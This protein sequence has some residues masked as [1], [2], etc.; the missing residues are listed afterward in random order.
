MAKA[1]RGHETER[2]VGDLLSV[3]A[4]VEEPRLAQVYTHLLRS[5]PT[6]VEGLV[7]ELDV[8]QSTAYSDAGTLVELGVVTR[9]ESERPNRFSAEGLALTLR[10]GGAEYTVTA[11]LIA[12]L[13]RRSADPDLELFVER[14]GIERLAA[15]LEYAIPYTDGEMSERVA[16]RELGLQAVEGITILQTLREVV[17]AM[18]EHDPFFERIGN[19][20]RDG[21]AEQD[22]NAAA[23]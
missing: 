12:A 17:L 8:A 23:E 14:H 5:G 3:A 20:R 4:L 2:P 18:R 1:E 10:S 22:V 16:A 9:E 11:T 15:A 19:A 7:E 13:A 21:R 6:T